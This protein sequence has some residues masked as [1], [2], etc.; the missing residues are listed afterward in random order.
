VPHPQITLQF[1]QSIDGRIALLHTR[2][3][4]S[5]AAGLALAH[6][7]RA[8]HDAVLVGSSTVKIDDPQLTVRHVP[9][10]NPRRIVLASTLDVPLSARVFVGGSGVLVIGAEGRAEAARVAALRQVGAEVRLVAAQADGFVSL[11]AAL[12]VISS[13]GV[14]R[15]L[16][17]GGARVL[18]AFLREGLVDQMVI[19]VVPMF[20]GEPG[21]QGIGDISVSRIEDCPTLVELSI[22]RVEAS[23]VVRGKVAR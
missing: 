21:I 10:T 5:S 1:A 2:T 17:E 4:L 3:Q 14:R 15:L 22:E 8:E 13:F 6:R 18:T 12:D 9:G 7:S 19:E 23:I 11:P 20:L 16:V